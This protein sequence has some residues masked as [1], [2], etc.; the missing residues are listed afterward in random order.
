M[1][2]HHKQ[3][4]I[5]KNGRKLRP[6]EYNDKY[7]ITL[8][9]SCHQRGH[10]KFDIPTKTINKYGTFNFFKKGNQV[11]NTEVVGLPN[12][13]DNS[14]EILPEIRREDFVD[15]SEPNLES[16]TITIKYGTGMPIDVIYSYIQTDY[17][18]DGYNDAMCNSDIQYKE[19][20]KKIINNGLKMLFEQVRLRYESDIRDINV[21]IDI[22]ETQGLTSSSMSLKARKETYNEHLKR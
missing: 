1:V 17:E 2:V 8:C 13:E 5:D 19:S 21:Q 10:A 20:K 9:S 3:Y 18:Q 4:H 15:D 16:N 11:N 22:V 6:W 14:K 12:V 7:L